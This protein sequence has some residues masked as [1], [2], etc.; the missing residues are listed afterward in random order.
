M[1]RKFFWINLILL[2]G[3]LL[4]A[5]GPAAQATPA[6]V[7]TAA[8]ET[9]TLEAT[10]EPA[11]TSLTLT[12]ARGRS[13]T[14]DGI[15]HKIVSL[16]P[17]VTELLFAVGAGSQVVGRDS[18]SDY[19]AET[20][21]ITDVGGGYSELNTELILSLEPDL[22]L[23]AEITSD[24]QIASLEALNLN[25]F[26]VPNPKDFDSLYSVLDLVAQITGH[27]DTVGEIIQGLK[28][29]V[30]AVQDKLANVS[31][32]PLVYYELDGTDPNAPWTAGPGTFVDVLIS[33]AGGTN[34]GDALS[35]DWAQISLEELVTRD[36]D[37]IVLGS[38]TWGGVTPESVAQRPGWENL[39]AVK[40][41]RVYP[42]DDNLVSRPGPRLVD[43]LEKL[44]ALLHPDLFE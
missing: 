9:P 41:G 4:T 18:Y 40:E 32:K 8:Q 13:V 6:A 19:P 38:A 11:P 24:E 7:P 23:A 44:A 17:S 30:T 31:Q 39:T 20:A 21:D 10:L 14:L 27:S 26:V 25:V 5:C 28:T 16:A 33:M 3:V 12:D 43:G 15:P 22:V 42:F 35:G 34:L 2:F 36:P 29:R 1:P 37:V